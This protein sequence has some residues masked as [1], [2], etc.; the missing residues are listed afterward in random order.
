MDPELLALLQQAQ[1]GAPADAT[2]VRGIGFQNAPDIPRTG[3]PGVGPDERSLMSRLIQDESV[4]DNEMLRF[5][6]IVGAVPRQVEGPSDVLGPLLA[7]TP[8]GK[9]K[10]AAPALKLLD[11]PGRTLRTKI[12][13]SIDALGAFSQAGAGAPLRSPVYDD[14]FREMR[15]LVDAGRVTIRELSQS[16]RNA[17]E[18]RFIADR[19]REIGRVRRQVG[20]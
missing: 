3:G 7:A 18:V 6:Q 11:M 12:R 1:Q 14:L 15:D 13:N 2:A 10:K 16:G 4:R 5:G 17:A 19:L 9:L 8:V 20:R